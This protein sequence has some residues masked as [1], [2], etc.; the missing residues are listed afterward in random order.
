MFD[1]E[2]KEVVSKQDK[3]T[4]EVTLKYRITSL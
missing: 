3:K 1:R 4:K 2:K